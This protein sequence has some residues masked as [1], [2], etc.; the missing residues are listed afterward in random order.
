MEQQIVFCTGN[1]QRRSRF[2]PVVFI[3]VHFD[4][5]IARCNFASLVVF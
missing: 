4:I 3:C 1:Y 2:H 5:I